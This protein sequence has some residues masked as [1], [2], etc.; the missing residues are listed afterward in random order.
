MNSE[1]NVKTLCCSGDDQQHAVAV[2]FGN[3]ITLETNSTCLWLKKK[4]KKQTKNV[5]FEFQ[6]IRNLKFVRRKK[7]LK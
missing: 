1:F 2:M 6:M 5:K 4:S 3:Q 7:K